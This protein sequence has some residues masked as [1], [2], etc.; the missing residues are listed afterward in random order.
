L[1]LLP[2]KNLQLKS[3]DIQN[4]GFILGVSLNRLVDEMKKAIED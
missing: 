1:G 4:S 3:L 2:Q